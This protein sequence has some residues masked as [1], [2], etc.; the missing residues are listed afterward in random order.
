MPT[1]NIRDVKLPE[2]AVK[3]SN[4]FTYIAD[5][6]SYMVAAVAISASW[7]WHVSTPYGL[8]L[9]DIWTCAVIYAAVTHLA[10]VEINITSQE[11]F[12]ELTPA[13]RAV[14]R[15]GRQFARYYQLAAF[16]IVSYIMHVFRTLIGA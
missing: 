7:R 4:T 9:L 12:A 16:T 13:Q 1:P 6:S 3:L 15:L 14:L 8:P 2:W 5:D 11:R 10:R